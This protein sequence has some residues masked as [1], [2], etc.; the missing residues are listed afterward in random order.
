[1][2]SVGSGLSMVEELLLVLTNL[3]HAVTNK[4]LSYRFNEKYLKFFISGLM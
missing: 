4:D 3:S 2:E 1:M